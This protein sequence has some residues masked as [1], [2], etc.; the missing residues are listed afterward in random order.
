MYNL[1]LYKPGD[2]SRS[3]HWMTTARTSQLIVRETE[4]EDQRSITVI[5][6]TLAPDDRH[7]LFENSV[8]LAASLLWQLSQRSYLLRLIVHGED[9]GVGTGSDHLLAMLRLLAL[10]ERRGP[11]E[12][13]NTAI[14][15]FG[16]E[17]EGGYTVALLPWCDPGCETAIPMADRILH[18]AQIEELVRDF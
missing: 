4:A 15:A 5:L 3:I 11:A 8:T 6:S 14:G 1:R 2:D 17:A 16:Y 9:S 13:S 12:A 10:C 7:T 18:A